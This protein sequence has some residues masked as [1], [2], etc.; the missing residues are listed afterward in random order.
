MILSEPG[1]NKHAN[2]N[3][4]DEIMVPHRKKVLGL[5]LCVLLMSVWVSVRHSGFLPQRDANLAF[6]VTV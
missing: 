2:M 3:L 6:G 1:K 5:I 4:N